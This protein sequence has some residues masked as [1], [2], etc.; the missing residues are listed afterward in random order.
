M[1]EEAAEKGRAQLAAVLEKAAPGD[2]RACAAAETACAVETLR[3]QL[4]RQE[5]RKLRACMFY[6][7]LYIPAGVILTIAAVWAAIQPPP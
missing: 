1:L 3:L 2:R 6:F 7:I 5:V 4:S